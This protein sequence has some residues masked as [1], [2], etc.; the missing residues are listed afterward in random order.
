MMKMGSKQISPREESFLN[1][2]IGG[3]SHR[4]A[5]RNNWKASVN[6]KDT[7]VD[8][9]ASTKFHEEKVQERYK[10]LIKRH[11]DRAIMKRGELLDGLKK[12][13]YMAM[14]I[15]PTPML[16]KEF[17]GDSYEMLE[18]KYKVADLKSV[19]S[20]SQQIAKLEGWQI[21]KIEHS[22]KIDGTMSIRKM[23]D[24][25]IDIDNART[26]LDNDHYGLDQV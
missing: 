26:I 14:G 10:E 2:I 17:T 18:K 21:D 13:F 16:I 24:A 25:E 3:M 12:A 7:T 23:S 9:K 20:I 6:W 11:Q 1:D 5:Y 8:S 22:G 19:A 4:K 15:E